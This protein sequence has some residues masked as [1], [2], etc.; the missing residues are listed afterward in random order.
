VLTSG[1][2][3][4]ATHRN[5][6]VVQAGRLVASRQAGH[7]EFYEQVDAATQWEMRRAMA[8]GRRTAATEEL[9]KKSLA[10]RGPR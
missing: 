10:P 5:A 3:I 2:R 1:T 9:P 6:L 7:V 8:Q 4:P